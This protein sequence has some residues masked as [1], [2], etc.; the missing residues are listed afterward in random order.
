MAELMEVCKER[1]KLDLDGDMKFK[2][3]MN[4]E[5]ILSNHQHDFRNFEPVFSEPL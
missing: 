1:D 4:I 3:A 2:K 5:E